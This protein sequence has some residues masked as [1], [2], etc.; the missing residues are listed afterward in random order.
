LPHSWFW[1]HLTE[2]TLP[3]GSQGSEAR[4]A[5][6]ALEGQDPEDAFM[7]RLLADESFKTFN[8]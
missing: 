4:I 6:L 3:T 8:T 7:Y 2:I 5:G 1:A